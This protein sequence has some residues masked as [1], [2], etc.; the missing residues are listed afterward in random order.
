MSFELEDCAV[1]V[2][3]ME[4]ATTAMGIGQ[5]GYVYF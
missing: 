5:C 1:A 3:N 4:L 2:Q